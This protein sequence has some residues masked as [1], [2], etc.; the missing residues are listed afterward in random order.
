MPS[1]V[2]VALI[3]AAGTLAKA[4]VDAYQKTRVATLNSKAHIVV[5]SLGLIGVAITATPKAIEAYRSLR[6]TNA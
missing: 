3:G 2:I 4:A 6:K 5:A 1:T